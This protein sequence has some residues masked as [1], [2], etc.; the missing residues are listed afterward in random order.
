MQPLNSMLVHDLSVTATFIRSAETVCQHED[1]I[2]Y[3]V[4]VT[5]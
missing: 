5:V 3:K 2:V 4:L 1:R